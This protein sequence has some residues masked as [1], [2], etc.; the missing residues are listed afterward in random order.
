MFK[1]DSVADSD[2]VW[3][4]GMGWQIIPS[5]RLRATNGTSYRAPG[6]YELY[7]GNLSGFA[8]QIA[9]DPCVNWGVDA[10]DPRVR[11][12]CLADG[13]PEDY[14][15]AGSSAT[16]VTGG[17][18]GVL[19]PETSKAFTTG[20]V[21][22]PSFANV[23]VSLDYF[24]I[25]VN[26]QIDTLGGLGIVGS[27]Y[28]ADV[29][30]NRFCDL[31]ERN[32]GTGVNPYNITAVRD[33]YVNINKQLTR[34]YDLNLRWDQDFAFGNLEVESQ[35]TYTMEDIFLLF[36]TAEEGGFANQDQNGLVTRP[37]LVGNLR[38]ALNRGDWTYTWEMNYVDATENFTLNPIGP[39]RGNPNSVFDI[40]A[41]SRLYH[42]MSVRYEAD[43]WTAVVGVTNLFDKDP[44]TMSNG[45]GS[46]R[47]GTA[48]A[49]ATQYDWFGRSLFARYSYR[50]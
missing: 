24:E 26:D 40:E 10:T 14:D 8:G 13:I 45:G 30:P 32:P 37:K 27:C 4:V 41:E 17:G 46:T 38:T 7:L 44:P 47:Y 9:I 1:Y 2:Y 39:F 42:G 34:G 16:I 31:F 19:S 15:G 3:K 33:A 28:F 48:P 18:L 11:A 6:L 5:V 43:D 23:S 21:F 35:M 36:D 22:T 12:N 49:F 50:F 20:I 29:F 25:Q